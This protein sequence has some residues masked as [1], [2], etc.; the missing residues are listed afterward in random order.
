MKKQFRKSIYNLVRPI[1]A[2]TLL[3]ITGQNFIFPFYH[4]VSD[5]P[6]P[7][8]K[9]L[10]RVPGVEQFGQDL[11]FLMRH[12]TPATFTDVSSYIHQHK[13]AKQPLF[14]LSFDDGLSECFH[15]IA[16]I[17][18]KRGI[19]A[20]FFI[21]PEFVDNRKMSHRQKVSLLFDHILQMKDKPLPP[22]VSEATRQNIL[23]Y[24][25]LLDYLRKCSVHN[26]HQLD[27]LA[28]IFGVDLN[29]FL[30]TKPYMTHEQIGRLKA[31]G[32]MIGSHSMDHAEFYGISVQEM[33]NQIT[34]SLDYLRTELNISERLFAFPFTDDGVPSSFFQFLYDDAGIEASFGTAGLKNDPAIRHIQ[35][36]PMEDANYSGAKEIIRSEYAYFLGKAI[37][38]RNTIVRK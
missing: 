18:K 25:Q 6:G 8:I 15:I 20:A 3:R 31:D 16:P 33:K 38:G 9:H 35:R 1:S 29:Q 12:F 10:Y 28:R 4:A 27:E 14:F 19:Q 17:L 32:H 7:H 24:G 23:N 36:I 34:N 11:D 37:F 22:K 30:N 13:T 26:H 21:N 5:H 2:R